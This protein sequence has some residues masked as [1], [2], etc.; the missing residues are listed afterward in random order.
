MTTTKIPDEY[1]SSMTDANQPLETG[2]EVLIFEQQKCMPIID[3][4][5]RNQQSNDFR[6]GKRVGD[7]SRM[8][9]GKT[10]HI[11]GSIGPYLK[12]RTSNKNGS[13]NIRLI[14]ADAYRRKD[15]YPSRLMVYRLPTTTPIIDAD[16]CQVARSA[17]RS[18][19]QLEIIVSREALE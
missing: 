11:I 1:A 5:A 12:I 4:D 16:D 7:I 17:V 8:S 18:R 15:C 14:S 6:V 10:W 13:T 9:E 2:K 19:P 3:A